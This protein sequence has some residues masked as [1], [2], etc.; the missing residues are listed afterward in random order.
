M[1]NKFIWGKKKP[2]IRL[3]SIVEKRPGGGGG[4]VVPTLRKS[5]SAAMLPACVGL[6]SVGH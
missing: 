2:R 5:Y 3:G 6:L 4:V 1:I